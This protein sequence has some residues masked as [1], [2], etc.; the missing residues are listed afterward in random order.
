[1]IQSDLYLTHVSTPETQTSLVI[2][3]LDRLSIYHKE[4]VLLIFVIG[5]TTVYIIDTWVYS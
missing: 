2:N 5:G 3:K 4:A 1:M